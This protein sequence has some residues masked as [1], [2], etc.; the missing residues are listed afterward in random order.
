MI[1]RDNILNLEARQHIYDFIK[2]NPGL[3]QREL[4]RRMNIPKSTILYHIRFLKKLNLIDENEGYNSKYYCA[5][6]QV[7][8]KEKQIINLF[9]KQV[10][11]KIFLYFLFSLA[12]SKVELSRE[13]ELSYT[14]VVRNINKM[15]KTGIIEEAPKSKSRV[16]PFLD[17]SRYIEIKPVRSEK[18]YRAKIGETKD[19]A[20]TVLIAHKDD[21]LDNNIVQAYIDYVINLDFKFLD[22]DGKIVKGYKRSPRKATI[23]FKKIDKQFDSV[24]NVINEI[25]KPPFCA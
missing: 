18:F 5:T 4:S 8:V 23:K 25:V 21:L 13:L 11:C 14:T 2:N 16:Y 22:E 10:P 7:G 1:S 20:W 6:R 9:R 24:I 17:T 15:L 19:L 12:C 3:H